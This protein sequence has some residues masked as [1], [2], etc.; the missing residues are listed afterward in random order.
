MNWYI[1]EY[2]I[3]MCEL[4]WLPRAHHCLTSGLSQ[5]PACS[6]CDSSTEI[7]HSNLPQPSIGLD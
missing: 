4:L 1:V 5:I 2:G 3:G 6:S 7:E